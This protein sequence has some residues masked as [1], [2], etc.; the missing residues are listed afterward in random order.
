VKIDHYPPKSHGIPLPKNGN[1]LWPGDKCVFTFDEP[2]QCEKPYRFALGVT[3]E[4]VIDGV[5][6]KA[7]LFGKD[8]LRVVCVSGMKSAL[9]SIIPTLGWTN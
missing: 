7:S 1:P 9:P 8:D 6:E 2:I 4:S 5:T 3:V